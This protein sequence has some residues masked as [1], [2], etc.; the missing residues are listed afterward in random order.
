VVRRIIP[1]EAK[2]SSN[3]WDLEYDF[4]EVKFE[5]YP[6]P[7]V[8]RE[9]K[10]TLPPPANGY[11]ED[12]RKGRKIRGVMQRKEESNIDKAEEIMP[13]AIRNE[14]KGSEVSE[15]KMEVEQTEQKVEH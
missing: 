10:F 5:K 3:I 13:D 14:E 11:Y 9:L 8:Q 12:S 7:I 1:P 6:K 2:Q 15:E 4:G